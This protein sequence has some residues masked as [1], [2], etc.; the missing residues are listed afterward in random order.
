MREI[1]SNALFVRDGER[2]GIITG[3]NLS[4]A[5]VLRR[6]PI[7]TPVREFAHFDVV[8]LRPDDFVSSALM[9]MTKRQQAPRRGHDGERYVG[10]LEDIDLLGFLAGSAQVVAGRIDR[11][12][13]QG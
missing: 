1:D 12:I 10:I 4:K 11:A 5:V 9:L 2:I 7:E 3:M 6:Q 13:E 8:T